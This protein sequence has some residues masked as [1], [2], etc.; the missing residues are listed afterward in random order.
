MNELYDVILMG[1]DTEVDDRE[2]CINSIAEL[3][4]IDE[5]KLKRFV[6]NNLKAVVKHGLLLEDARRYQQQILRRGGFCNYR[7][8]Q[9]SD[10]K[11]ELAPIEED[12]QHFV[13]VC[14]A[15]K[16]NEKVMSR[17]DL[18]TSCPHCGVV[19]SKYER[20]SSIKYERELTKKRLLEK[21]QLLERQAKELEERKEQEALRRK[22]EKEIL[23][24]LGLPTTINSRHRLIVSGVLIWVIGIALGI[25]GFGPYFQKNAHQLNGSTV[26]GDGGNKPAFKLSP[27]EETLGQI[28]SSKS[29]AAPEN[30]LEL[31]S[32]KPSGMGWANPLITY[33]S[34]S[35]QA[36]GN[37]ALGGIIQW[38]PV[39]LN[40]KAL[41]QEIRKDREWELFL[42]SEAVRLA[43]LQQTA[44]AYV[45][46]EAISPVQVKVGALAT[47]AAYYLE[48]K[49][50]AEANN[51]LEMA[52]LSING[53]PDIAE[54][55]DNLGWLAITLWRLGEKQKAQLYL[56]TAEKLVSDLTGPAQQSRALASL[57]THQAQIG[58]IK[59]SEANFR[60][61]SQLILSINDEAT[62]LRA[63]IHLAYSYAQSGNNAIPTAII[64]NALNNVNRIND[65]TDQQNLIAEIAEAF[66]DID[67]SDYALATLDKL[68]SPAKG[69]IL[70]DVT[71]K[72]AYSDRPFD[73]MKGLEKL[74][75]PEYQ[76]RAAALLSLVFGFR[77]G[78]NTLSTTLMQTAI[79]TQ[80]QIA[81]PHDQA[82]VRAE[83]A[84]YL[85]HA[86][87]DKQAGD[88]AT[89]ALESARAIKIPQE[90]DTAFALLAANFARAKQ[91]SLVTES[92]AQIKDKQLASS[93][94]KETDDINQLFS[95]E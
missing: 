71:R 32:V 76:S 37:M 28:S 89:K 25:N 30:S 26:V 63:Y 4:K 91:T 82:I 51:V 9:E 79:A 48:K 92:L 94:A 81:N 2:E 68:N 12:K 90:R 77:H 43:K 84:R 3:L 16:Y 54:R 38:K 45:I 83:M 57:A 42:A 31:A 41:L 62:K 46:L 50:K 13:F 74:E 20:I 33:P 19:P 75:T 65:K 78:M 52:T 34:S 27:Q 53:L 55:V 80:D 66:A 14:H 22:L 11:L 21:R 61:A 85:A 73:A 23:K 18:P 17:E 7:P 86:G 5:S 24:E 72:L 93:M 10:A 87:L 64:I 59:Q 44:A 47:L 88:W 40:D 6:D 67:E 95:G 8:T 49:D 35:N 56:Q 58:Q 1:I 60:Q 39:R 36:V 69:R 70:F 29:A 15:C